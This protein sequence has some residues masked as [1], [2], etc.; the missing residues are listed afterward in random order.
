V[1]AEWTFRQWFNKF[2][3]LPTHLA[4]SL[5]VRG[6]K[7]G[8][9]RTRTRTNGQADRDSG[10]PTK[11]ARPHDEQLLNATA[12]SWSTSEAIMWF[13][14]SINLVIHLSAGN[15][16]AIPASQ[17]GSVQFS[18]VQLRPRPLSVW[19]ANEEE[20]SESESESPGEHILWHCAYESLGRLPLP[21]R[22]DCNSTAVHLCRASN[23]WGADWRGLWFGRSEGLWW[24]W[25]DRPLAVSQRRANEVQVEAGSDR[26]SLVLIKH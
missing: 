13:M 22:I 7:H 20:E 9:K 24:S 1:S 16:A 11:A 3:S 23:R 17:F 19:H 10:P 15:W 4:A 14:P 8:H 2:S 18:S 6:H 25:T 12:S 5:T 26:L 21:H